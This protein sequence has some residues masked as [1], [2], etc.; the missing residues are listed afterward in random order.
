MSPREDLLRRIYAA[1]NARDVDAVLATLAPDVDWPNG[2]EG[3]RVAGREGVREYWTRQWAAIDPSVEPVAFTERADGR[4]AVDVAQ[5]AR[6]LDGELLG[7]GRVVHVYAFDD[8]TGLVTRM[9]IE[10]D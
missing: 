8:A 4:L 3:G 6:A 1:F 2:W 5:V 10:E 9:D 7:E